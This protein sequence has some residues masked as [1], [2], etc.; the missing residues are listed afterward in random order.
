MFLFKDLYLC[1][2][3]TIHSQKCNLQ[4]DCS[5]GIAEPLTFYYQTS[6]ATMM[7]S[8][9]S[10]HALTL[11]L[12]DVFLKGTAQQRVYEVRPHIKCHFKN[13]P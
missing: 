12:P 10:A 6:E 13:C 9:S 11:W 4:L 3:V 2:K 8:V 7:N 1:N 5:Q